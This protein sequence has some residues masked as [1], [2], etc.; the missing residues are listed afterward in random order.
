M[1]ANTLLLLVIQSFVECLYPPQQVYAVY[2][3]ELPTSN[4]NGLFELVLVSS[5][6][7]DAKLEAM[8]RFELVK[9]TL[10]PFQAC[11]I[12]INYYKMN[13]HSGYY[14]FLWKC[15]E[16]FNYTKHWLLFYYFERPNLRK[17]IDR[18]TYY[19]EK[20]VVSHGKTMIIPH[21]I[22]NTISLQRM[23][24]YWRSETAAAKNASV[25]LN[26][27]SKGKDREIDKRDNSIQNLSVLLVEHEK[28]LT[29]L[30]ARYQGLQKQLEAKNENLV[31][32]LRGIKSVPEK[33][34][35]RRDE[36]RNKFGLRVDV[37][38]Q[39]KGEGNQTILGQIQPKK[40]SDAI[41]NLPADLFE[42]IIDKME[43]DEEF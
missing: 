41:S 18:G 26:I 40:F 1:H 33:K 39:V 31:R 15:W 8:V 23:T 32:E 21:D 4:R 43:M 22:D 20:V 3:E 5:S 27:Q 25:A 30:L 37:E 16:R 9:P 10:S 36:F 24:N 6:E 38:E 28:R 12:V 19:D 35:N 34:K 7:Y 29:E 13:V 17:V 42:E 14:L 2:N 11:P